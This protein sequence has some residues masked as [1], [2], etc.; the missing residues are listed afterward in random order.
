M[1]D[2]RAESLR[3]HAFLWDSDELYKTTNAAMGWIR[4]DTGTL[5]RLKGQTQ[6]IGGRSVLTSLCHGSPG[7]TRTIRS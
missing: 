4:H 5:L 7:T 1:S 6:G 2:A 3:N